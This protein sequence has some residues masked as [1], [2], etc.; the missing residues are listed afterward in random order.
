MPA[1]GALGGKP[2]R[3]DRL[4][5]SLT[6]LARG[7]SPSHSTSASQTTLTPTS[8]QSPSASFL[9]TPAAPQPSSSSLAL[10][11]T[12]SSPATAAAN[13]NL[14]SSAL[15]RL[16]EREREILQPFVLPATSAVSEILDQCLAAATQKQ[17]AWDDKRWVFTF[18]GRTVTLKE[19]A[20]KIIHW[21][22]R[23]KAAGDVA[24]NADP[25]HAA[26]PWAG[27]RFLLEVRKLIR[28]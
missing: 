15:Q 13:Y 9:I 27:V 25:V 21:L 14:L 4:L 24:V 1:T 12:T 19:K 22:D 18:A 23:F 17:R 26:L 16:S 28:S 20:D 3:R 8:R 10:V 7:R 5:T 2:R 11:S 6:S